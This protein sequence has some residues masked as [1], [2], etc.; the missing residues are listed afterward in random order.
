MGF[1]Y[2]PVCLVNRKFNFSDVWNDPRG[3]TGSE[4]SYL[5]IA[6]KMSDRGHHVTLFTLSDD[7][8]I[9]QWEGVFVRDYG[10][11]GLQELDVAFSWNES[12]PLRCMDGNAFKIVSWQLNK[13]DHCAPDSDD[14]VNMWMSPSECHRDLMVNS[15]LGIGSVYGIYDRTYR[16]DPSIW[17]VIPHGCEPGRYQGHHLKKVPGRVIW[18]SSPDRG[19]HWLL[20]EWPKIKRAVPHAT[21]KVFY[22]LQQWI[23][24]FMSEPALSSA[25]PDIVE[26]RMRA[27]Y[28]NEAMRRLSG[29]GIEVIGSVSRNQIDNEMAVAEVLAYSCDPVSWTEGFSVTLM[30]SCAARACP[31]TTAVDALPSVYGG[32]IPMIETPVKDNIGKFSDL[33]IRSLTD[34]KYREETNERV[35]NFGKFHSWDHVVD[36]IESEV[37]S[38]VPEFRN[39]P[40]EVSVSA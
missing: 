12:E 25:H 19:L 27:V 14:F 8:G 2:G 31:V 7:P 38:R 15:N 16:P 29:S 36:M 5:K 33:V 35:S 20:Q 11:R 26:Q 1:V 32:V 28:I 30:E 22:R 13:F 37:Q 23:D 24:Q 34:Q 40:L 10:E 4:L 3:L 6:K 9:D 18:A 39:E 21:L 17:T